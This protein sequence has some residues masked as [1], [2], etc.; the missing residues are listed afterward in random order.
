MS[1]IGAKEI[2]QAERLLR[3]VAG[4]D[5]QKSFEHYGVDR[6]AYENFHQEMMSLFIRRCQE[7]GI[8]IPNRITPIINTL[9]LHHF[10]VG[11]VAGRGGHGE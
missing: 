6:Q 10:M 11:V 2:D 7:S 5:T 4:M 8:A 9:M 1:T 3:V